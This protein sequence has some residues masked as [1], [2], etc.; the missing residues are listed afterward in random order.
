M[1]HGSVLLTIPVD[2]S[3][4][5][6]IR[7]SRSLNRLDGLGGKRNPVRIGGGRAAVIGRVSM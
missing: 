3:V 2:V 1:S 6:A 7:S 5:K 4:G